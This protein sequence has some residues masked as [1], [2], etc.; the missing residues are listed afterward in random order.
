MSDTQLIKIDTMNLN[1]P[2]LR[3]QAEGWE[4]TLSRDHHE[5]AEECLKRHHKEEM[6]RYNQ[7]WVRLTRLKAACTQLNG[8][9]PSELLDSAQRAVGRLRER[10]EPSLRDVFV[11]DLIAGK[12]CIDLH[13]HHPRFVFEGEEA[14]HTVTGVPIDVLQRLHDNRTW[15]N[16]LLYCLYKEPDN[17]LLGAAI[18]SKAY[19]YKVEL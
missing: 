16:K 8:G 17:I 7:I 18:D 15:S 14:P 1:H 13:D 6:R 4:T 11:E 12:S 9:N 5:G 19:L 3:L 10:F 2:C